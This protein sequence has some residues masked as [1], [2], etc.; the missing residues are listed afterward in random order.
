[1]KNVLTHAFLDP[2]LPNQS[3]GVMKA[4]TDPKHT[5]R[6]SQDVESDFVETKGGP[7][8]S[9][10]PS[11]SNRSKQDSKNSVSSSLTYP[12]PSVSISTAAEAVKATQERPKTTSRPRLYSALSPQVSPGVHD[13]WK[14][15]SSRQQE[16]DEDPDR[17]KSPA[18]S[19]VK[20]PEFELLKQD[21]KALGEVGNLRRP[22]KR[23]G[24]GVKRGPDYIRGSKE[25]SVLPSGLLSPPQTHL[26]QSHERRSRGAASIP[27][28]TSTS[29]K[30]RRIWERCQYSGRRDVLSAPS[31]L[32]YEHPIPIPRISSPKSLQVAPLSPQ[33]HKIARGQ[34]VILPSRNVLVDFR[35]GDRRAGGRGDRILCVTPDGQEV[36]E[37]RKKH[38]LVTN[39]TS[40][41]QG[42]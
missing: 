35:E 24:A 32:P 14:R 19:E 2:S 15:L 22:F 1:M 11:L 20:E 9:A 13:A 23:R 33:T 42:S 25:S 21:R 38:G 3:L 36:S 16:N 26:S 40:L 18:L 27:S 39:P 5:D 31:M 10:T 4:F 6:G 29:S 7:L 8:P 41:D 17:V 34:L 28:S 30:E 12:M 37:S